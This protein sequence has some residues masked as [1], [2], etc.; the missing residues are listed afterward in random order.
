MFLDHSWSQ[1]GYLYAVALTPTSVLIV[2]VEVPVE[3][4]VDDV[5]VPL[6]DN[7]RLLAKW[8]SAGSGDGQF[9]SP[10]G[11]A[12]DGSGNV[13]VADTFHFRV[14]VFSASGEFLAKWGTGGSGDGQFQ[15]PSAIAVDGSGNVYVADSGNNRVQVFSVELP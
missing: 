15:F 8:G 5:S 6:P 7:V 1:D 2:T 14:Q 12:V 10:K 3:K 4:D 11:I 9:L 13:Y